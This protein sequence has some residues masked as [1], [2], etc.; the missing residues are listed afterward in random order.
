MHAYVFGEKVEGIYMRRYPVRND[1]LHM[2]HSLKNH[3]TVWERT[4]VLSPYLSLWV[5]KTQDGVGNV[6]GTGRCL[7]NNYENGSD[8]FT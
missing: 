3:W 5:V 6:L 2:E 4:M 1:L 7:A 8:L